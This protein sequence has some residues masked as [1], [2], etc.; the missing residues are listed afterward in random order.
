MDRMV[1]DGAREFMKQC[2]RGGL[3]AKV[4]SDGVIE[5]DDASRAGSSVR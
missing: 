3:R 5:C 2:F 4:L 1:A